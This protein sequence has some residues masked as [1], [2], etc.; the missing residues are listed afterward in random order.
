MIRMLTGHLVTHL[1]ILLSLGLLQKAKAQDSNQRIKEVRLDSAY[2]NKK[3]AD[4]KFFPISTFVGQLPQYCFEM[5]FA[6][7]YRFA[8]HQSIQ[9]GI[10]GEIPSVG[11]AINQSFLQLGDHWYDGYFFFGGRGIIGYRYY[12]K[13]RESNLTGPYIGIE[14][15][16]NGLASLAR[17]SRSYEYG[18]FNS[19]DAWVSPTDHAH[20][21]MTNYNLTAGYQ[22]I[23]YK[24]VSAR[25]L[26]NAR[27]AP[28]LVLDMG[29]SIGYRYDYFWNHYP[30][31][32][33]EF[34]D[35]GIYHYY[36][37]FP[38]GGSFNFSV[39]GIF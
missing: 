31:G 9:F 27:R 10:S 23:R 1:F 22:I 18:V 13:E 39:G 26:E 16:V 3:K 33:L 35:A 14:I 36:K 24:K 34:V 30:A 20:L 25:K 12:L 2:I 6:I 38:I 21:I 19:D 8:K 7:E 5:Q 29:V 17:E 4:F 32:N 28:V 11:S 37:H 15:S